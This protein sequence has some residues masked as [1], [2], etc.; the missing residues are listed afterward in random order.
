M[1]R[2]S[3][4]AFALLAALAAAASPRA[5]RASKTDAFEGKIQPV[6]GQ[7]FQKAGRLELTPG[8]LLSLNDAFFTKY[9]GGVK[10]GY[11]VS[12]F[13]SI[14]G[15]FATG[16]ASKTGSAVVC[17]ANQPCHSPS[18]AQL[19]QVPG[20]ID[21]IA[22]GEVQVSPI[23]GKLNVF[24]EQVAHFDVS[25]LGG[26]DWI[27]YDKILD[28]NQATDTVAKGQSPPRLTTVGFHVGLG[29]RIFF[30]QALALRAEVKDYV[31]QVSVPSV[32]RKD[33]QNQ[34]FTEIGLSVFF[35]FHNRAQP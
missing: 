1:N 15:Q 17:P 6:S 7:L 22:G 35:P 16:S 18:A 3:L 8:G 27:Q 12:E 20:H 9:F 31:Y 24:S 4:R 14:H 32:Q 26:A 19:Y 10:L 21:A 2:A 30:S 5:A 11:H 23:Y 29:A 28:L 33:V 25:L 13:L 34:L